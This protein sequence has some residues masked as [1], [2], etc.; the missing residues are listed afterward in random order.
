LPG[1]REVGD[2]R[3]FGSALVGLGHVQRDSG[4][5]DEARRL[6]HEAVEI[7]ER[8]E[9]SSALTSTLGDL[10]E[11]EADCGNYAASQELLERSLGLAEAADDI[12]AM[13]RTLH[14]LGD[15]ALRVGA[16]PRAIS[17]YKRALELTRHTPPGATTAYCLAGMAAAVARRGN[18]A[19]AEVLWQATEELQEDLGSPLG[20]PYRELYEEELRKGGVVTRTRRSRMGLAEAL[21]LA[22]SIDC[23][24]GSFEK[25]ADAPLP[26]RTD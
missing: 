3:N 4:C 26:R 19:T 25:P 2:T 12:S 1:Y 22:L 13:A 24:D 17:N 16:F 7:F 21:Q 5:H 18:R 15:L 11:L 23:S 9:D 20:P 14:G 8:V 6:Y 10:G